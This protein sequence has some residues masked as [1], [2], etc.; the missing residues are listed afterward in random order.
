MKDTAAAS[1]CRIRPSSAGKRAAIAESLVRSSEALEALAVGSRWAQQRRFLPN[2]PPDLPVGS[3]WRLK[4]QIVLPW[5]AIAALDDPDG[6]K[7]ARQPQVDEWISQGVLRRGLVLRCEHCPV[8]ELYPLTDIRQAYRCR[9]CGGGST[10]VQARWRPYAVEPQW[11]YDLHLAVSELVVNTGDAPLPAT[12][13]LKSRL[14]A[15][16]LGQ[17]GVRNPRRGRTHR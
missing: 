12:R 3:W 13:L 5:E 4:S 16:G 10:L 7:S 8:L 9:R 6:T 2:M 11:F 1:G 17:R 14:G 15:T